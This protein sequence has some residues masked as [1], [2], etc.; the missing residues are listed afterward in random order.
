MSHILLLGAGFSRNWGG[1]LAVEAFEYLLGCPEVDD[2]LRNL[3]WKHRRQGGFESALGE[4]QIGFAQRRDQP[5]AGQ[6]QKLEAAVSRM[7][8]AMNEAFARIIDFEFQTAPAERTHLL[9]TFLL[10]FDAIFTLNQDLLLERHYLD[11]NIALMSKRRWKGWQLPGTRCTARASGIEDPTTKRCPVQP[12]EFAI[13]DGLQPYFKLHGSSNWVDES[14][15]GPLLVIGGQKRSTIEQHRILAWTHQ[16]FAEYLAT[17]NTRLMVIGYSFS[18]DHINST[19][20]DAAERGGLRLFIVDLLGVDV[21]DEHRLN[22]IY[23]PGR[24]LVR[25]QTSVIGAS[26]STVREIF[27]G[28]DVEH[29]KVLRFF[30]MA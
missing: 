28:D 24:L 20:A 19:I 4:L 11:G 8:G 16:Q 5:T 12:A 1:W 15:G 23:V 22:P 17:P 3:L 9:R 7:F 14:T 29:A 30:N 26:R 10:G 6:L 27:G 13:T 18:D 25:L 21:L 2:D